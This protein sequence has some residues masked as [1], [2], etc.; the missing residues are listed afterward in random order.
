MGFG[1]VLRDVTGDGSRGGGDKDNY[2]RPVFC[3]E[4]IVIV[5]NTKT[6]YFFIT[7]FRC[8]ICEPPSVCKVG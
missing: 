2:F 5:Y 7:D 3:V 6:F 4:Y 1:G 8:K